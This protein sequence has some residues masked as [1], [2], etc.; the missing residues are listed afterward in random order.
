MAQDFVDLTPSQLR[1]LADLVH[2][3]EAQAII[4]NKQASQHQRAQLLREAAE[5]KQIILDT[6]DSAERATVDTSSDD[7]KNAIAHDVLGYVRNLANNSLQYVQNSS[8]RLVYLRRIA[9]TA[10]SALEKLGALSIITDIQTLA[11]ECHA[12][13]NV[14][15]DWARA[16]VTASARAFSKLLKEN[17][18]TFEQLVMRWSFER[19]RDSW[20]WRACGCSIKSDFFGYAQYQYRHRSSLTWDLWLHSPGG[21]QRNATQACMQPLEFLQVP[22]NMRPSWLQYDNKS[23]QST[24]CKSRGCC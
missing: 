22:K 19:P 2:R 17:G 23:I 10:S 11:Q 3:Q 5:G 8:V 9:R 15:L 20:I 12:M 18:L 13:R 16:R 7:T 1:T 4:Q 6:L 14:A 21:W 24:S